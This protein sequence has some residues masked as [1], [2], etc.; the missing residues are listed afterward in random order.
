MYLCMT[1]HIGVWIDNCDKFTS[2]ID[3]DGIICVVNCMVSA[4]NMFVLLILVFVVKV[5]IG[6]SHSVVQV[7]TSLHLV[8]M[9][10]LV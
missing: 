8:C 7:N 4:W 1:V 9:F 5:V 10:W 2:F 6:M 3:N